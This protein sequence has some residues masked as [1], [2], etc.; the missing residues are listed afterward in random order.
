M[1]IA[2]VRMRAKAPE[3]FSVRSTVRASE[4]R[5]R[6][7]GACDVGSGAHPTEKEK[8]SLAYERIS[9]AGAFAYGWKPVDAVIRVWLDT[10]GHSSAVHVWFDTTGRGFNVCGG[11][12][13]QRSAPSV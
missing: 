3:G 6:L 11:N 10:S 9:D 5:S 7:E 1:Y 4:L 2:G 8:A 12:H 13:T